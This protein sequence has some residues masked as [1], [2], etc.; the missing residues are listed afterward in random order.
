MNLNDFNSKVDLPS[1]CAGHGLTGFS[2]LRLDR[3]GWFAIGKD[4]A[5]I[6]TFADFLPYEDP[7]ELRRQ[8]VYFIKEK[9]QYHETPFVFSEMVLNRLLHSLQLHRAWRL[10]QR[11]TVEELTNGIFHL[12]IQ[13]RQE[14]TSRLQET[15]QDGLLSAGLGLITKELMAQFPSLKLPAWAKNRLVIPTWCSPRH[16]C[17]LETFKLGR[18]GEK[19]TL[20][21]NGEQ[22][23]YGKLD[24]RRVVPSL[25]AL[26]Q[27]AGFTWDKKCPPWL[28]GPV[29]VAPELTVQQCLSLWVEGKGM[30]FLQPGPLE[31]IENSGRL[32]EVQNHLRQLNYAQ[33][34]EL[35]QRFGLN[36]VGP[37]ASQRHNEVA[38]NGT[39]Y[40][41][42]GSQYQ[43]EQPNGLVEE[44]TNFAIRLDKIIETDGEYLRTGTLSHEERHIPFEWPN[45]VFSSTSKFFAH[46]QEAFFSHRLGIPYINP[47]HRAKLLTVVDRFN[48]HCAFDSRV[49]LTS[50]EAALQAQKLR[51]ERQ[52]SQAINALDP[53][54]L[55]LKK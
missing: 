3:F 31:V 26:G 27:E 8:V 14:L 24:D 53:Q 4:R 39:R 54:R 44:V 12:D 16:M 15:G 18:E 43:A 36:L 40:S 9:R 28:D 1:Y 20:F 6:R 46:V 42:Q 45:S 34:T 30:Q 38:F 35:E 32:P 11:A 37:W 50:E 22:G 13:L 10:F 55:K 25:A 51:D 48:L 33:V 41:Q 17:S 2:F 49:E 7:E 52:Q 5:D 21:L 47:K 29:S 23:W 19:Q